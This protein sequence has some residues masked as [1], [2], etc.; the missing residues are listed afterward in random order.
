M[1]DKNKLTRKLNTVAAVLIVGIVAMAALVVVWFAAMVTLAKCSAT[2]CHVP[3]PSMF[4]ELVDKGIPG[5][6][7]GTIML[8]IFP[9]SVVG[10]LAVIPAWKNY[11]GLLNVGIE[12]TTVV[13]TFIG[14]VT[15]H[16]AIYV[17]A[18][19]L[20]MRADVTKLTVLLGGYTDNVIIMT[21]AIAIAGVIPMMIVGRIMSG[22]VEL[23][24]GLTYVLSNT[25][26]KYTTKS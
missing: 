14:T 18:V 12:P 2:S 23:L 9:L 25:I 5:I 26:I 16:L 7:M 6:V 3:A 20:F 24:S 11:R 13:P 19:V 4:S 8:I 10:V 17:T 22:A 1:S 15:V 21:T